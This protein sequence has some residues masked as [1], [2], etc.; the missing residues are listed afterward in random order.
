MYSFYGG[1]QGAS[2]IISKSFNSVQEM[3]DA[4]KQGY[5][6]TEVAFD[7]YVLI[8]TEDKINEENGRLY[9]RGYEFNKTDENN[10]PTGG[11]VYIGTIVGPAGSAS[12]LGLDTYNKVKAQYDQI[13]SGSQAGVDSLIS[14]GNFTVGADNGSLVP[15]SYLDNE[16]NRQFNDDITWVSV[17]IRNETETDAETY[18]GFKIPYTVFDFETECID[19]KEN[20]KV[21]QV[22]T[23]DGQFHPFYQKWK[24]SIPRGFRGDSFN[25]FR[26]ITASAEDGVEEYEGQVE[27]REKSNQICVCDFVIDNG[28]TDGIKTTIYVGDYNVIKNITMSDTGFITV[29]GTHNEPVIINKDS[30]IKYIDN[31]EV[32]SETQKIKVR[33]NTLNEQGNRLPYEIGEPLN[34]IQEMVINPDNYHL[35]V[36]YN[37]SL[38]RSEQGGVTYNGKDGWVDLGSIKDESGILIGLNI[39]LIKD[40]NDT[41]ASA[42]VYLN[43]NY[44]GGLEDTEEFKFKGKV[45]TIGNSEDVK[46]FYAYDYNRATWYYLG[47]F[48]NNI[49]KVILGGTQE[50]VLTNLNE[51]G[52]WLKVTEI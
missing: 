52:I 17:C 25:N 51:G 20:P 16:N 29:E 9:R 18:V 21:E 39:P 41:V 47:T 43:E 15:G 35:L 8:N 26:V 1:K 23:K 27:D 30:A 49:E 28:T 40:T 5:N 46:D 10:N 44:P 50:E 4:F 19:S 7:E 36:Y 2:F 22:P 45:I 14:E 6:Y 48:N 32:D 34:T 42:I 37:S 11:A 38:V 31:I 3:I 33:Y 13:N 24:F 12:K